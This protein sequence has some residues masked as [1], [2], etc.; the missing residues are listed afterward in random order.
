VK[1]E[2]IFPNFKL[3]KSLNYILT[4]FLP[5]TKTE[6]DIINKIIGEE[7]ILAFISSIQKYLQITKP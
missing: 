2:L 5:V 1:N 7:I 4:I 3:Q 6:Q